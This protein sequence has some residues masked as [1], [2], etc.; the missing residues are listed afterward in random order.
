MS[1]GLTGARVDACMDHR[2]APG[3]PEINKASPNACDCVS[4]P[5]GRGAMG[6]AHV[7]HC[8]ILGV[9]GVRNPL[10]RFDTLLSLF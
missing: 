6:P 1:M 5:P 8:P 9:C 3:D 7:T 10:S 2:K 4:V